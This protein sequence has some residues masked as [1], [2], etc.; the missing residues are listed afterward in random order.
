MGGEGGRA[1]EA[2]GAHRLRCWG[3]CDPVLGAAALVRL[4]VA[5]RQAWA[6]APLVLVAI[7]P[8]TSFAPLAATALLGWPLTAAAHAARRR[9][10]GEA[11]QE[12]AGAENP[13]AQA[14]PEELSC[15][16]WLR[17]RSHFGVE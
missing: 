5:A 10:R 16:L 6:R 2:G 4:L 12:Q 1:E 15:T 7:L 13:S 8:A 11:W 9:A 17:S 14:A 3:A